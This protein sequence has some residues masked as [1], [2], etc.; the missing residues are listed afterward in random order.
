[1]F[2][3]HGYTKGALIEKLYRDAKAPELYE[4]ANESLRIGLGQYIDWGV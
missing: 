1:V 4:G 3:G 2:G